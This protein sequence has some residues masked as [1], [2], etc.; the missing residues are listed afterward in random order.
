MNDQLMIAPGTLDLLILRTVRLRSEHGYGIARAIERASE[1]LLVD[2]GSLYPTLQRL[3]RGGMISS[4]WGVTDQK[5]R[6]R[7]YRLT[8][9]GAAVLIAKTEGSE[10]SRPSS[11]YTPDIRYSCALRRPLA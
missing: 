3:E 9:R 11:P 5:R 2:H 10:K 1:D 8:R 6:A 4:E 7:Y